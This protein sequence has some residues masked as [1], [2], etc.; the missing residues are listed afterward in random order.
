MPRTLKLFTATVPAATAKASPVT[1]SLAVGMATVDRI[2]W[3]VPPGP[4]GNLGWYLAM[5]GQQV[6][7]NGSGNY[8]V[9]DDETDTWDLSNLPDEGEWEL[10]GYNVGAFDHSVYLWFYTTPIGADS[11]ARTPSLLGAA[12]I[13]SP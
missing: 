5:G 13:S 2:R 4:R 9:A 1:V 12:A 11:A 7:P 6:L 3:R 8:I 10:I